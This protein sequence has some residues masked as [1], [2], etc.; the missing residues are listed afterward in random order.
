MTLSVKADAYEMTIHD[1]EAKEPDT[2]FYPVRTLDVGR[3]HFLLTR[4]TQ[5]VMDRY[6]LS[7]RTLLMCQEIGPGMVEF[8]RSQYP[9]ARSVHKNKA[10]GEYLVIDTFDDEAFTILSNIPDQERYWACDWKWERVD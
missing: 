2:S 6:F 8:V 9:D 5:G 4:R 7:G 3:Y 10:E 1:A